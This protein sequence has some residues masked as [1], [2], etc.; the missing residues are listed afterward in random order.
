MS[1][2]VD[3]RIKRTRSLLQQSINALLREKQFH[4]ITVQDITAR[5]EVNRATF[6]AHFEDKY[7][8][9]NYSVR[10]EFLEAL[11]KRSANWDVY[12]PTHLRALIV[13]V[14]EFLSL[15]SGRC[16]SHGGPQ[17]EDK[18]FVLS[19][20]Q[21][22]VDVILLRWLQSFASPDTYPSGEAAAMIA[23]WAIFGTSF[24]WSRTDYHLSSEEAADRI[25]AIIKP[26]LRP[27]V[28]PIEAAVAQ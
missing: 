16:P 21:K 6:Y 25:L 28:E 20:V 4:T 12:T 17:S 7:A 1:L 24:Q 26:G 5:A 10:E 22:Q 8:L 15:F 19:E 9:L 23:S 14:Y 27:Y 13:V 2:K 3:P 18:L 11:A